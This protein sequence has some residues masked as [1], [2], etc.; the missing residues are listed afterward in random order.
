MQIVA[1]LTVTMTFLVVLVFMVLPL[2]LRLNHHRRAVRGPLSR[3]SDRTGQREDAGFQR[4]RS[5]EAQL[6]GLARPEVPPGAQRDLVDALHAL[7]HEAGWPSLRA[8]AREAGCSHTTVSTVFSSPK[9]PSWGVLELVVE[10]MGGDVGEFH[11]LW[12]TASGPASTSG[13]RIAI[14][15]R[16]A[17][18]AAVRRHLGSGTGLLLVTGEAGIGKTRLVDTAA[19]AASSIFVARGACRPL[20]TQVPLL[21]ITDVLRSVYRVDDGQWFKEG[22]AVCPQY[23]PASL[24]RLLPELDE[25]GNAAAVPDDDWW[26]QRLFS[27]VGSALAAL[28]TSRSLA[29]LVEDLH[30]A[31]ATTRD[32][33]EHLLSGGP[34]LPLVGTYRLDDPT[35]PAAVWDW[36]ARIRRL[37]GVDELVLHP[38][39]RDGTTEQLALLTGDQPDPAWVDRIHR[40]TAGQPLFTEQLVAQAGDDQPL[41]D[42][43]ADLLDRR[44]D[45]LGEAASS[46]A[47]ALGIADRPLTH[48]ELSDVTTLTADGLTVQLRDLDRRQLLTAS[49]LGQGV[50]LRHPL[51]A[52]A[53]RRRLV[54][55]EGADVHRRLAVVLASSPDPSAAE[56]ANHWLG[57]EDAEQELVWR[58]RA[59]RAAADRFAAAQEADEWLRVLEL[60]PDGAHSGPDGMLKIKV[61]L[62]CMD[63]LTK[64]VRLERANELLDEAMV[65]LDSLPPSFVAELHQRASHYRGRLGDSAAGM[66]HASRAVEICEAEGPTEELVRAL[67]QLAFTLRHAGRIREAGERISRAVE[68]SSVLPDM[69]HYRRTLAWE[70]WQTGMTG[71]P[72]RAEGLT[73]KAWAIELPA[74]HPNGDVTLAVLQQDILLHAG[75][76]PDE[77]ERASARAL[78]AARRWNLDTFSTTILRVN[79]AIALRLDGQIDQAAHIIDPAT[80]GPVTGALAFLHSERV[81]LDV[82]R[83]RLDAAGARL[84]ELD[85]L[86]RHDSLGV[87]LED[88]EV[89]AWSD[90]WIGRPQQALDRLTSSLD[91]IAGTEYAAFAGFS[92]A[93][94]ARSAADL[95]E[96]DPRTRTDLM[97]RL[98]DL[99]QRI[100]R[101]AF[102]PAR[103]PAERGACSA[104]WAAEL[105][106]LSANQTVEAWA[107][108]AAGWDQLPRPHDSAYCRWRGAAVAMRAGQASVATKLLRRAQRDAREHLPLL[109]AIR[110]IK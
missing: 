4:P 62:A 107:T 67:E 61:Y 6:G 89:L 10:A 108:A 23:V 91:H 54:V 13:P 21:P 105:G 71:D 53:V 45:G 56:V 102:G 57:A 75:A 50:Q 14:A 83:G 3:S 17:E 47:R 18:L 64:S 35:V 32:L 93:L 98:H 38:L 96:A 81:A 36:L 1:A 40:R 58:I 59:A 30:W 82:A 101:D 41:P 85:S 95:A 84:S 11:R 66:F 109:E 9:L 44:L 79:L 2:G 33:I 26:R 25:P 24:R 49:T 39:T 42:V 60:W 86:D 15:G 68:V 7:H 16:R 69:T 88:E 20:S 28:A 104:T 106:R 97:H 22:L 77:I 74:P 90:L 55:G 27:A 31:D 92:L 87:E 80:A 63:A 43:L 29:V 51:L 110:D 34:G 12:L 8:L 19:G 70:A 94:A 48:L 78:D 103:M 46:V 99:G 52:E 72:E 73:A 5:R 65:M 37:S 100:G 76:G